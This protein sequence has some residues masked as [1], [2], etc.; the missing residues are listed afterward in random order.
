MTERDIRRYGVAKLSKTYNVCVLDCS[1]FAKNRYQGSKVFNGFLNYYK[2]EKIDSL[3][4]FFSENIFS[5]YVDLISVSNWKTYKLRRLLKKRDLKRLLYRL[6]DI[7]HFG[8]KERISIKIRKLLLSDKKALTIL[9]KVFGKMLSFLTAKADIA[10]LA[11]DKALL[12]YQNLAQKKISVHSLDYEIYKS[13]TFKKTTDLNSS[14]YAVFLD[15]SAPKH[16]D[17]EFHKIKPPVTAENYFPS[18]TSF[19]EAIEKKYQ[20]DVVIAKHPKSLIDDE[21]WANR[22]VIRGDTPSLVYHSELVIAHYTTAIGFA[23]MSQ[24][25]ILQVTS[26]EYKNSIRKDRLIAFKEILNLREIN[27]DNYSLESYCEDI[28]DF[29]KKAYSKYTCDYL[30][31]F[32]LDQKDIWNWKGFI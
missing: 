24:K 7:P 2:I 18:M 1:I 13:S 12:N 15:Q 17:Y 11:G 28:F 9:Q 21:V 10:L 22:T 32:K 16:P 19:F 14:K 23:V 4:S 25:P 20:I 3:E 27:I 6:N 8:K 26:D 5:I 30:K 29:D 31:S